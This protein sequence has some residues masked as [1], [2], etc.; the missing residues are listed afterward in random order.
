[1]RLFQFW[2][3]EP[4]EDVLGF[5]DAA[6]AAATAAGFDYVRLD[7][8]SGRDFVAE[9]YGARGLAV[10]DACA[11][12]VMWSDTLRLL[13]MD[14]VGGLYADATYRFTGDLAGF[15]IGRAHV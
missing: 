7:A 8:R 9:H 5:M 4:P 3:A 10:W 11:L 6:R 14:V 1:M 15:E 2:D 12:P 13:L